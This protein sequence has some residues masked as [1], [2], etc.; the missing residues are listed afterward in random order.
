MFRLQRQLR[1]A[2]DRQL[3]LGV[4]QLLEPVNKTCLCGDGRRAYLCTQPLLADIG[5][6]H[7]ELE[8]PQ[9]V[10]LHGLCPELIGELCTA[11]IR[12]FQIGRC[13]TQRLSKKF[14]SG[15]II[16]GE[17]GGR[18]PFASSATPNS[19]C[20]SAQSIPGEWRPHPPAAAPA[21]VPF[22]VLHQAILRAWLHS[23]KTKGMALAGSLPAAP[24]QL[25]L[26]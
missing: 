3:L 15:A 19:T 4:L 7:H 6:P 11:G 2:R 25:W 26:D 14:P 1:L 20:C 18:L 10:D 13:L 9:L 5:L 24:N 16:K 22:R 8:D 21:D 12:D 23:C 17:E